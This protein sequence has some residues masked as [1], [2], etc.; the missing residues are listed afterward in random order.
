[1]SAAAGPWCLGLLLLRGKFGGP[2]LTLVLC[3]LLFARMDRHASAA[4]AKARDTF[5]GPAGETRHDTTTTSWGARRPAGRGL[6]RTPARTSVALPARRPH[7]EHG[8]AAHA[9]TNKR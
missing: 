4:P 8:I 7:D 9:E 6:P 5:S 1:M 3:L 2:L